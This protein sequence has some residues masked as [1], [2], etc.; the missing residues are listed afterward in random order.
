[1][2]FLGNLGLQ[3]ILL[4]LVLLNIPIKPSKLLKQV[5]VPI[6]ILHS[7]QITNDIPVYIL[8]DQW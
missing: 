4:A 2:P 6:K 5:A 1:M 3:L 7:I 8:I